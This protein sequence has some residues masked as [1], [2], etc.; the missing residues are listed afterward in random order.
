MGL[1]DGRQ[2]KIKKSADRILM[3]HSALLRLMLDRKE[4]AAYRFERPDSK[5]RFSCLCLAAILAAA[6][7]KLVDPVAVASIATR[8]A[9]EIGL[10]DPKAFFGG[11]IPTEEA[12]SL[13]QGY[14][15]T[16][17]GRFARLLEQELGVGGIGE[18]ISPVCD[19][20]Q[21]TESP[22]PI[23]PVDYKRLSAAAGALLDVL[24][25]VSAKF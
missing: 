10:R 13:G 9:V 2:T 21:S 11:K 16:F 6:R 22:D 7:N 19:L 18:G 15:E 1:F 14:V 17:A 4:H 20:I 8:Q 5:F 25:G 23:T 24:V 12:H 3:Y